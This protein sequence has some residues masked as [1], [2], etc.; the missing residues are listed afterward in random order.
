MVIIVFSATRRGRVPKT[1]F[2]I[3]ERKAQAKCIEILNWIK[4]SFGEVKLEDE[5]E[6][7]YADWYTNLTDDYMDDTKLSGYYERK[8]KSFVPKIAMLLALGD[9]RMEVKAED[10]QKVLKIFDF[11]EPAMHTCYALAGA[12]KLAPYSRALVR[13]A[14]KSNGAITYADVLRTFYCELTEEDIVKV[15]TIA[16]GMGIIKHSGGYIRIT[17]E[18]AAKKFLKR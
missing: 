3:E 10:L 18:K 14:L 13:L 16:G 4:L 2:G 6:A 5:A 17:D 9:R 12:N 8:A 11:T 1:R 7:F 15:I